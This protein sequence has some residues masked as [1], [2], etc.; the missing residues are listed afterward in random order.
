[1]SATYTKDEGAITIGD[2]F[3]DSWRYES[4]ILKMTRERMGELFPNKQRRDIS[5]AG[6]FNSGLTRYCWHLIDTTGEADVLI[7][8]RYAMKMFRKKDNT[9]YYVIST[10]KV[11]E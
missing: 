3:R 4:E 10:F 8:K 2:S 1:M 5:P 6:K 7:E 11:P 9:E